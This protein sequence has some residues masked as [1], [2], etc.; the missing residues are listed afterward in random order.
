MINRLDDKDVS[1][2]RPI[3]MWDNVPIDTREV[4]D[5]INELDNFIQYPYIGMIFYSKFEDDYYRVLSLEDGYRDI[6]AGKIYRK[7]QVE[8]VNNYIKLDN[9]FVGSY[10]QFTLK[11]NSA[12]MIKKAEIRN[13]Y[14]YITF[15]DGQ[16]TNVG[17][18]TGDPGYCPQITEDENNDLETI[19][20]LIYKLNIKFCDEDD[21]LLKTLVTPNL[22]GPYVVN[23]EDEVID[24]VKTGYTIFTLN[25]KK[26]YKVGPYGIKNIELVTEDDNYK[27][28]LIITFN[29]DTVLN[30]GNVRGDKGTSIRILGT[31]KDEN[32][33]PKYANN[34]ECYIIDK[35][36]YFYWEGKWEN[37]GKI[38]GD[39]GKTPNITVKTYRIS[40]KDSDTDKR[41]KI[42]VEFFNEDKLINDSFYI[43]ESYSPTIKPSISTDNTYQLI[44]QY[45][46]EDGTL[47][48]FYTPNLKGKD[49]TSINIKGSISQ[50]TDLTQYYPNAELGDA[51]IVD[52]EKDSN[53]GHLWVYTEDTTTDDEKHFH[54]FLDVGKIKGPQGDPG[55]KGN[56]GEDGYRIKL[57]IEN[58]ILKYCYIDKNDNEMSPYVDLIEISEITGPQGVSP[59]I[60]IIENDDKIKLK[61]VD[62]DGEKMTPNLKGENGDN[63]IS[64]EM[65][66]SNSFIQ[67]RRYYID[68]NG[69][70]I[71]PDNTKDKWIDLAFIPTITQ[72]SI[73]GGVELTI[74]DTTYIIRSAKNIKM[75][76]RPSQGENDPGYIQWQLEGDNYWND[77]ISIDKLAGKS[78]SVGNVTTGTVPNGNN[79]EVNI[80]K[81][82]SKSNDYNNVYD[83]TFTIPEG[84][85]GNDGK[86]ITK[87]TSEYNENNE[88]IIY[89]T[90]KDPKTNLEEIKTINAGNIKGEKGDQGEDGNSITNMELKSY[91]SESDT[92][93]FTITFDKLPSKDISITGLKGKKGDSGVG[94]A[95]V[96]Q[97]TTTKDSSGEN[98]VTVTLT[99]GKTSIIKIY[100][101]AK[102]EDGTSVNIK[103]TLVSTDLLPTKDV[104][105]GD[106]WLID[107]YLWVYTGSTET[108]SI[109]GF[110]NVGKIQGPQGKSITNVEGNYNSENIL[111]SLVFTITD[112]ATD[113]STRTEPILIGNIKG[114]D[115]KEIELGKSETT[116]QWRYVGEEVW[117]DLI[118]LESITGPQGVKGDKGEDGSN[119]INGKE[120]ELGKSETTIQWRYVGE[121]VWKDLITLESITGPQGEPGINGTDGKDGINGKSA[122]EI[123]KEKGFDGSEAEWLESLK[124]KNGIDGKN[125]SVSIIENENNTDDIY[126]LD[127]SYT[128]GDVITNFTTPNL[129]GDSAKLELYKILNTLPDTNTEELN[130]DI[131]HIYMI[132]KDGKEIVS[133]EA[134]YD[135]YIILNIAEDNTIIWEKIETTEASGNILV[136]CENLPDISTAST[137]FIYCLLTPEYERGLNIGLTNDA[138]ANKNHYEEWIV[139]ADSEG[140]KHWEL[141]GPQL[142]RISEAMIDYIWNIKKEYTVYDDWDDTTDISDY[143]KDFGDIT[144]LSNF[145]YRVE[146]SNLILVKY[147]GSGDIYLNIAPKY[148]IGDKIYNVTEIDG[149]YYPEKEYKYINSEGKVTNYI[150]DT[151][152]FQY[153][154][155]GIEI[156]Q[157]LL[158]G[159]QVYSLYIADSITKITR[160]LINT[161]NIPRYH[162]PYSLKSIGDY[163]F[164]SSANQTMVFEKL[165]ADGKTVTYVG[166]EDSTIESIGEYGCACT[167]NMRMC[168]VNADGSLSTTN[169]IKTPSTLKK[170]SNYSFYAAGQVSHV[171]TRKS[172]NLYIGNCAFARSNL[173]AVQYLSPSTYYTDSSFLGYDSLYH[174]DKRVVGGGG[175]YFYSQDTIGYNFNDVAHTEAS[176]TAVLNVTLTS[177]DP[178]FNE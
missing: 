21:H 5:S 168:S 170:L 112:P 141:L 60:T 121:E 117:K 120:I 123:A 128:N 59:V 77:L 147:I 177:N 80:V 160:V 49:G 37:V 16:E 47:N 172:T 44:I 54:G 22:I 19:T 52:N 114:S 32:D 137:N 89:F 118:T 65:R 28:D 42:K 13:G 17:Y 73:E 96:N 148:K 69:N 154:A 104:N 144:P 30:L 6:R 83:F 93:T 113:K 131:N 130:L 43:Y 116:I 127:I 129:K 26:T 12:T 75:R 79:A 41:T 178:T 63:G 48:T 14:L 64:I 88:L 50:K 78:M 102:G 15:Y 91:D 134:N 29:D 84:I 67:Y 136:I 10:E 124:G 3:K 132:L 133:K 8:N 2:N 175:M 143:Q 1:L 94:I 11:G 85:Q 33:L 157:T 162:I 25:N 126:K 66:Y 101:G 139:I 74:G 169:Y 153:D 135:K 68:K 176:E 106:G 156:T 62:I 100:N 34:G 98:I 174:D 125:S 142:Y 27:K 24:G 166:L 70:T 72:K 164:Y 161:S 145:V 51:Y 90:I 87:I 165:N 138:S 61:I 36:L 40:P 9:Y 71:Y 99:D 105:K 92:V 171:D 122:Y 31:L 173:S 39:D 150:F 58:K 53:D 20:D 7:S 56:S 4:I 109:N 95:S 151:S 103:G 57:K 152:K 55:E 46:N 111:E 38:V 119:G 107:G 108:S 35:Y 155:N 140:N 23:I 76:Y 97:T 159:P 163:A 149:T 146:G 81:N 86:G 45:M 110:T 158:T 115:G 167:T 82:E 18:V